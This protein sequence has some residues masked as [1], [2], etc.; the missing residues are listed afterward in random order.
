M[1][2]QH[3]EAKPHA[4]RKQ[5]HFKGRRLTVGQ[6]LADM[7]ANGWDAERAAEEHGLPLEAVNE[8]MDYG[9]RFADVIAADNEVERA[10]VKRNLGL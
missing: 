7:R 5:L 10:R 2:Y 9:Q 4:W 8:A 1:N 3:L 6:L